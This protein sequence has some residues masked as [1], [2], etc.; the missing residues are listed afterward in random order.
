MEDFDTFLTN[1][2]IT[3]HEEKNMRSARKLP[4]TRLD[5]SI[6]MCDC[7]RTWP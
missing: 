6:F 1:N 2:N 7:V 4:I 3:K 5:L